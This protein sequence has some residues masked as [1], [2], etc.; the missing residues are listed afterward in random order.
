VSAV[1]EGFGVEFLRIQNVIEEV[2]AEDGCAHPGLVLNSAL[3]AVPQAAAVL[4]RSAS[5]NVPASSSCAW[6]SLRPAKVLAA[7]SQ[8]Y[9]R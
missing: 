9:E 3:S 7:H 2:D 4:G 1:G 5:C 8:V 6:P